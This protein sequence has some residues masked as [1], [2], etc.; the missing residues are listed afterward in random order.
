MIYQTLKSAVQQLVEIEVITQ[1]RY[2]AVYNWVHKRLS[3]KGVNSVTYE[4]D[5]SQ[6]ITITR[7]T[8]TYQYS[9]EI[10]ITPK[11]LP[12][13]Q[14]TELEPTLDN[15][16]PVQ[17]TLNLTFEVDPIKAAEYFEKHKK[18]RRPRLVVDNTPSPQLE[19]NFDA[20]KM[21]NVVPFPS[22]S[23]QRKVK[24]EECAWGKPYMIV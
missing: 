23:K 4:L 3:K 22:G 2:N 12:V 20:F 5:E 8:T 11:P 16:V 17:L 7:D 18:V 21:S 13:V 10:I 14:P 15:P 19:F 9:V 1:D 6:K 24:F